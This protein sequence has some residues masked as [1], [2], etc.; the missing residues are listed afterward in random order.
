MAKRLKKRASRRD[1]REVTA[2]HEA[3]H[4]V[5]AIQLEVPFSLASI[6]ENSYSRGRVDAKPDRRRRDWA[7]RYCVSVLA[8]PFAQRR[9]NPRSRWRYAG[10]GA[11]AGDRFMMKGADF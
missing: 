8:G 4:A 7:E 10:T 1:P 11:G 2:H 9:Y 5:I 3:G 6:D